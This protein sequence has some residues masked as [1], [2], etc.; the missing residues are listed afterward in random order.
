MEFT[1]YKCP[2]C[3]KQFKSGDDV[4]VCPECGTPHHRECYEKEGHCHFADRH[5]GAFSFEA[6][7]AQEEAERDERDAEAGIV[8]CKHCGAENPKE[9]FYCAHCGAP[10]YEDKNDANAQNNQAGQNDNMPPFGAPFGGQF[11]SQNPNFAAAFDPM[12][13][14]KSDEVLTDGVT[15]GEMAKYVGKN[16]QYFLRVFGVI[17]KFGRSRFNFTAFILSGIYFLY[18]KMYLLGAFLTAGLF[19]FS[20]GSAYVMTLPSWQSLYQSVVKMQTSGQISSAANFYG[21]SGLEFLYFVLPVLLQGLQFALM[22]VCGFIA[23]RT[24]FKHCSKRV[25]K[26]KS[27]VDADLVGEALVTRGGVNL[28]IACALGVAFVASSYIPLFF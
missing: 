26:I 21:L 9:C 16:T 28:P 11:N 20:V 8:L 27:T 13:G 6:E 5:G 19:A 2:V 1:D 22:L 17:E 7:Q 23:N 12:A 14:M 18:R 15:A 10:L 3:E 25:R 4:V 24:Y